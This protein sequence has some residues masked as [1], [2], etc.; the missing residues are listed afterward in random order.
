MK[1]LTIFIASIS[2]TFGQ[3]QE[4]QEFIDKLFETRDPKAFEAAELSAVKAG[5][6]DQ[7]LVEARFLFIVDQ[8]DDEALAA[9]SQ[10]L[11]EQK[12]KFNIDDSLIFAVP[13]DFYAIV[14]YSL[15]VA[16]LQK[17]DHTG[18]KKH[19][20]EA[21][22]LSPG[23][24]SIFGKLIDQERM[25]ETMDKLVIDLS[26]TLPSQNPEVKN[27]PLNA[28][29]GESKAIALHFWSPWAR[30]SQESMND[31]YTTVVELQKNKI[32]VASVLLSG[33]PESRQDADLFVKDNSAKTTASWLVDFDQKTLGSRLRIQAFPTIVLLSNE[34]KILFNGHPAQD[35]FWSELLK[36]A[37]NIKQPAA[38]ELPPQSE[39]QIPEV[40]PSGN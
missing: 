12:E 1:A 25:R 37:P 33:A 20:T 3:V 14:E 29:I 22:W 28:H 6:K 34:G 36:I 10:I 19:I 27:K 32:P 38:A 17:N 2:L 31:F 15:A 5:V 21:F 7:I 8:H 35:N 26:R 11:L 40:T 39:P 9:Y 16:A 18:F 23:Q 24:A 4:Q 30:E 13:E